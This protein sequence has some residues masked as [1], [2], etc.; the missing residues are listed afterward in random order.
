[1]IIPLANTEE[2]YGLVAI[3]L[4]WVMAVMIIGLFSLGIYMTGL[5]YV[6]SWYTEAPHLHES[7]GLVVFMLLLFRTIWALVN[8]KPR[9]VPMSNWERKTATIVHRLFYFLL[10]GVTISGYLI[11]T[12]DG[13][14]IELFNWFE[15]P[16]LISNIDRQED[17]AGAVHYYLALLTIGLTGLH[18]LAALKH[19]FV[20]KDGALLRMFG[21][22]R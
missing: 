14:S 5:E 17:I 9:P 6:D 8:I 19:H 20:D 15:V 1:M 2:Q 12:A 13:R 11:P 3:V 4:H 21:V 22:N 7:F 18:A 16:A 10:F